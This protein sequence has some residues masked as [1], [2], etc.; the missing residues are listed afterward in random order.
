M[1]GIQTLLTVIKEKC[2]LKDKGICFIENKDKEVFL[3]YNELYI[4]SLNALYFFQNHGLKPKDELV[5]Q[6]DDNKTFVIVFWACIL[7]GIVPVPLTIGRNDD[8][9]KKFFNVWEILNNPY[10]IISTENIQKLEKH[11][12]IY[13]DK[14]D[15]DSILNK[16]LQVEDICIYTQEGI[17]Y[18][19]EETDVAYIQFSSGSTDSPHGVMLTHKNLI[20]NMMAITEA[21]GYNEFDSKFSWM[22]LTHD[23]GLIG[24]HLCPLFNGMNQFILSTN[25]FI[26]RPTLWLDKVTQHKATILC[27]PN[28]G[29][30]YLLKHYNPK[31]DYQ[32]DLSD[33]RMIYNGAEPISEEICME[34]LTSL[35]CF[36]LKKT[37]MYPVYGLAEASLAVSFSKAED[38][39]ISLNIDRQKTHIGEPIEIKMKGKDTV[40]FVNVGKCIPYCSIQIKDEDESL[41]KENVIGHIWIKGE[42]VTSG[43]YNNPVE[44]EKIKAN[45]GWLDTGDLGFIHN[46]CYFITG[47]SKDI[48]FVNGQNYYPHDIERSL[49]SIEEIELGKVVITGHT[50]ESKKDEE[51]IVFVLYKGKIENFVEIYSKVKKQINQTFGFEPDYILPVRKIPKTTSGKIQRFRLIEE[52]K[53]GAF[54][55]IIQEILSLIC[56]NQTKERFVE[57]AN[58]TEQKLFKIWSKVLTHEKFSVV[59]GFFEI[60]GN[61]LKCSQIISEIYEEFG[62]ELDYKIFFEKQTIQEIAKE[63]EQH[64]IKQYQVI[65]KI[66]EQEFYSL[67]SAQLRLYYLW[68]VD[69]SSIAYN[70]PIAFM[71]N[72]NLDIE[73][74]EQACVSLIDRNEMLRASFSMLNGVPR[75]KINEKVDFILTVNKIDLEK[76]KNILTNKVQP[77][78]LNKYPLFRIELFKITEDKYILFLDFHHIISDGIS[79]SFLMDNLFKIYQ[80][81]KLSDQRI[82]YKDYIQWET[83][84]LNSEKSKINK[85]FWLQQ[86]N[87]SVPILDLPTDFSRPSL[88]D[89]KGEKLKFQIDKVLTNKLRTLA[90]KENVSLFALFLAA[91]NVLLSKYTGQEDIVIGIPVAGRCHIELQTLFGMFVNNLAIRSYPKGEMGFKEFLNKTQNNTI[92]ALDNQ[93]YPFEKLVEQINQKREVSRNSL[94]DTMFIYQ[95]MEFPDFLKE[96]F[97][98]EK[99]YFDPGFSKYDISLEIFEEKERF[100]YFIEYSKA[101]FKKNTI[102]RFANHFEILLNSI[103]KTTNVKLSDLSIISPSDYTN[104]LIDFNKRRS[105]Y[106]KDKV[107]HQLIE[108]QALKFPYEIAVEFGC[109]NEEKDSKNSYIQF[110]SSIIYRLTYKEL[111]ERSSQFANYLRKRGVVPNIPI[112][113]ILG[114]SPEL[115]IAIL[116]VLKAGGCY[117]PLEK[118]LPEERINYILNDSLTRHV[119]TD[120]NRKN[121]TFNKIESINILDTKLYSSESK[122]INNINTPNNLAYIIY[123]SGTTGSPKGVMVEHKSLVNYSSFANKTY[124]KKDKVSFPLYTSIS[125]DLTVT[126]IFVP[127]IS[128]NTIVV[129]PDREKCYPLEDILTDN[130]INV[131]KATPSHLKVLKEFFALKGSE[132]LSNIKRFVVG[133]ESLTTKLAEEI[134]NLF[135]QKVEIYN[136]YGPTEATVGCMI[137]K[138][139]VEKDKKQTVPIGAPIDNT[140]I[141]LLDMYMKPIPIGVVGEIYISG[142]C[143]ARGY[144]FNS[145]LTEEKFL[146]NPFTPNQKIYKTGD[147]AKRLPDENIEFIGRLDQQVKI[148]GYRVDLEEIEKN[149]LKCQDIKECLVLINNE[150]LCAY[151]VLNDDLISKTPNVNNCVITT[152]NLE[153]K[154][155]LYNDENIKG[156]ISNVNNIIRINLPHY[157]HP[158]NIIAI[159]YIPLTNNGK[160]DQSLLPIPNHRPK[161]TLESTNEIQK[162]IIQVW[163]NVLNVSEIGISDNF[164]ELGGDSIKAVQIA[165]R[166]FVENISVNV[167]DILTYQ[168]IEFLS[169]HVD[170]IQ[171]E[172]QY[173]QGIVEGEVDLN[174]IQQ[175]FLTQNFKNPHFYN[176]TIVLRFKKEINIEILQK[177]FEIL[178]EH[179]DALRMNFNYDKKVMFYNNNHFNKKFVVEEYHFNESFTSTYKQNEKVDTSM[180]NNI[181]I[182]DVCQKIKS[183]FDIENTLLIKAGIF[184]NDNSDFLFITAHHLIIDG[185]SWRILMEDLYLIYSSLEK[186]QEIKLPKKTAS[187]KDWN[188]KLSESAKSREILNQIDYWGD[189]E[190]YNSPMVLLPLDYKS[191]SIKDLQKSF[192][193]IEEKETMFLLK[194]ANK[195][196]NTTMEILLVT[197]LIN[198]LREWCNS[199]T[200][201]IEMENHGRHFEGVDVTRTVGWFTSKFPLKFDRNKKKI[202]EQ[203]KYVKEKIK[204]VPDGGCG[205]EIL[206]Y[207]R[208]S[209]NQNSKIVEVRFN[210]LGQFE[211]EMNNELFTYEKIDTGS[212]VDL[213]NHLTT[214]MDINVMVIK[215]RLYAEIECLHEDGNSVIEFYQKSL[216]TILEHLKN[217]DDIHFTPNDFDTIDMDD[218]DLKILFD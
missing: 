36:G 79:I 51:I 188:V 89:Y 81:E 133:G 96:N 217:E 70:I 204:K 11:F 101:L 161:L 85:E 44:T 167:K 90:K 98:I 196:Y 108:E 200:I 76:A 141:Y 160:I 183:S 33:V 209:I 122:I 39:V 80:N 174:P 68:E 57:P 208:K 130:K 53:T 129:Y 166:L 12:N 30:S 199:N 181:K 6:I 107:I 45:G 102:I 191:Y 158:N 25:I 91:Y 41:C 40:S 146:E 149:I 16:S 97:S 172:T 84:Y 2:H 154:E 168:T 164:F 92:Q 206:K 103:V 50:S 195:P 4:K 24:F 118:D 137:Y 210:Y 87:E 83:K 178:I 184:K 20:Y 26:R 190:N 109:M 32:W 114:R 145:Q 117:L 131:L 128:G 95:N 132:Y 186:K 23:M 21:S 47:R 5:M 163:Q 1:S 157:M 8:H 94:F 175:W 17:I 65:S 43:Y 218:K 48:I 139:D 134:Y 93:Y 165:S 113:I 197:A 124:I 156:I 69:K 215:N 189:E 155:I 38:E 136:E 58:S 56:A 202:G 82:Q 10:L 18:N 105:D 110:S 27:S 13:I 72:C 59:Q 198:A 162:I 62:I 216:N 173:E 78:N 212:E 142:D 213:E 187:L 214:K 34:F 29:Y 170:V 112:A 73:R 60:G 153:D 192:F 19:S 148:N 35:E 67:S 150:L 100:E 9:R 143:L 180:F 63:I 15:F 177:T 182:L 171:G 52:F 138:Y 37:S 86:F 49:E 64:K 151:I 140:Q 77:Y 203:I 152:S 125:F 201:I 55:E 207:L 66:E 88:I 127:L 144:L 176:Q 28:F 179:H 120:T 106:P 116:G 135:N 42:N 126:S 193:R 104:L 54:K 61:S 121:A 3:S 14:G 194:D 205:Y 111:N 115:I 74:F 31:S 71:I 169:L 147:F 7:G 99:F 75:Q 123:T 46:G 211:N 159:D 119:I 22:P 185:I